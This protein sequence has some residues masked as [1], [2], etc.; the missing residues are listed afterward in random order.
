[1]QVDYRGTPRS[2]GPICQVPVGNDG[3]TF[4]RCVHA[5]ALHADPFTM[6][7]SHGIYLLLSASP[8]I[9]LHNTGYVPWM[10]D[11]QVKR[12][13]DREFHRF[14]TFLHITIYGL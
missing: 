12:T 14:F 8:Q 11:M 5:G 9:G 1:M 2:T 13:I 10:E 4:E 7:Y 6:N 3:E